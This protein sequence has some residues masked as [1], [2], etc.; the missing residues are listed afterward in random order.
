MKTNFPDLVVLLLGT[1][2]I[3]TNDDAFSVAYGVCL[4]P[5]GPPKEP[6]CYERIGTVTLVPKQYSSQGDG[7]PKTAEDEEFKIASEG[8]GELWKLVDE[9]L[10]G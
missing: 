10:F 6:R 7:G 9:G 1:C 5:C 2:V 4:N 8:N 3:S